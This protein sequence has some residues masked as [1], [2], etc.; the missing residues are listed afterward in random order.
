MVHPDYMLLPMG[1]LIIKY[2]HDW[3]KTQQELFKKIMENDNA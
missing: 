1:V 3:V 2:S